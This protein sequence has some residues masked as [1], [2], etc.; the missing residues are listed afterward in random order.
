MRLPVF[1]SRQSTTARFSMRWNRKRRPRA[2]TGELKPCP[3]SIF[4]SCG[5]PVLGQAVL[6]AAVET[7]LRA[8]PRNWGQSS[9]N[10]AAHV[11]TARRT[12]RSIDETYG[13]AGP[14]A[15]HH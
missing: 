8:G 1:A 4:H 5:G 7:P 10:E 3:T 12:R 9:A 11:T 15:R 13:T 6:G 14:V 2:T